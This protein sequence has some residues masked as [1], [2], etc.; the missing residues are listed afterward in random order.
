[1]QPPIVAGLLTL[2]LSPQPSEALF[3]SG[4]HQ[5]L[6]EQ[7]RC[8]VV[9]DRGGISRL[10]FGLVRETEHLVGRF[11]ETDFENRP[12]F[13]APRNLASFLVEVSLK[14]DAAFFEVL[15]KKNISFVAPL[16]IF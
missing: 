3:A 4:R 9:A 10:V 11:R 1:M 8:F 2:N 12:K 15:V 6:A 16:V 14:F 5:P 7:G 13:F